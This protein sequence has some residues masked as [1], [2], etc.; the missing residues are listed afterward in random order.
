MLSA[1]EA[2]CRQ[3][4]L[5]CAIRRSPYLVERWQ[6]QHAFQNT[7]RRLP[8]LV[9]RWQQ[10][11]AFQNMEVWKCAEVGPMALSRALHDS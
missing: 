6:Q 8:Y 4:A 2:H 3:C 7:F 9:Q 1:N 11:H 10:Q 5:A